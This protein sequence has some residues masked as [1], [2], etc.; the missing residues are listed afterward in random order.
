L[1]DYLWTL[2]ADLNA[3]NESVWCD[4]HRI[5]LSSPSLLSHTLSM[6]NFIS[7][8]DKFLIL[9]CLRFGSFRAWLRCTGHLGAITHARLP[10]CWITE[11]ILSVGTR[12]AWLRCIGRVH[13]ALLNP[14]SNLY[15]N[16]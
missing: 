1:V 7:L 15:V 9:R 12:G 8:F 13:A 6:S 11:P 3:K 2:G 10:G 4:D 5:S 16:G 14:C